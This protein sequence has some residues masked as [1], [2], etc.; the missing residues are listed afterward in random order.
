MA[1]SR[2]QSKESYDPVRSLDRIE[3]AWEFLRRN[4]DY[5]R[6]YR[7]A[8]ASDRRQSDAAPPTKTGV[9]IDPVWG[10]SYC[11]GSQTWC[12]AATDILV[13]DNPCH[14]CAVGLY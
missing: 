4:P 12:L 3:L 1:N 6:D 13:S 7:Y 14:S 8:L 5:R 11:L 10:L 9:V 2:W